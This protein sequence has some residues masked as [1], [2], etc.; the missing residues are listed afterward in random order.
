MRLEVE[1]LMLVYWLKLT[2]T[3]VSQRRKVLDVMMDIVVREATLRGYDPELLRTRF[4]FQPAR[5][6]KAMDPKKA[7]PGT[8]GK[9][10]TRRR[11]AKTPA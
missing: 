7:K 10:V 11:K 3:P 5:V 2:S 6:G 8:V 4:R 9:T 1:R